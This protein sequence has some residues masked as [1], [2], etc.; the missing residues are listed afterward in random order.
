MGCPPEQQPAVSCGCLPQPSPPPHLLP[1][2]LP[3][4]GAAV[5]SQAHLCSGAQPAAGCPGTQS[6]WADKELKPAEF[7]PLGCVHLERI[8]FV[9]GQLCAPCLCDLCWK[10]AEALTSMALADLVW[11]VSVTTQGHRELWNGSLGTG[12]VWKS[13]LV[14]GK[15]I[16]QAD[17]CFVAAGY[18]SSQ[19]RWSPTSGQM[20]S[21]SGR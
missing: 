19:P 10:K 12:R 21:P 7:L 5:R 16:S 4:W 15:G 14:L 6:L 11:C 17:V 2:Q 18:V 13:Y 1:A 20:T 3:A 9:A 8:Q